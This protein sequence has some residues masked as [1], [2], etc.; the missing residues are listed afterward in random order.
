MGRRSPKPLRLRENGE[1]YV[2]QYRTDTAEISWNPDD[3]CFYVMDGDDLISRISSST[4]HA[5]R[6]SLFNFNKVL[7]SKM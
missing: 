6:N 4:V 1:P 7:K 5:W 3:N 2:L